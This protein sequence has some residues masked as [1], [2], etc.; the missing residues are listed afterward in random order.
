MAFDIS[1]AKPVGESGTPGARGFDLATAKPVEAPQSP[2]VMDRAS[3]ALTGINRGAFTRM[4]GLPVD[5]AAN[6]LDLLK[7]AGGTAYQA[8]TGKP[9]ESMQLTN[10]AD[11][12]G[13]GDWIEKQVRNMG[14]GS[15]IDPSG[16][17]DATSRALHAGGMGVGGAIAGGRMTSAPMTNAAMARNAAAGGLSGGAGAVAAENGASPE[18]Q[19]LAS[20]SPQA[21]SAATAGAAR[22]AVRGGEAGRR[23]MEQRI[24]DL[25]EAGIDSPSLGLASGNAFITGLENLSSKI[26]GSVGL[27]ADHRAKMIEGMMGK[28]AATRDL[29]SSQYGTDVAGRAIQSDLQSLLR[30]RITDGFERVNDQ[31]V[32]SMPP[33]QRFPIGNSLNALAGATAVN[34]LAPATTGSFVQPRIAAL[35]QNMLADS[36]ETQPGMYNNQQVNVGLPVSAIREVR[37]GIGKEAASRAIMGTPEQA[38]YKQVYGG[39]SKDIGGAAR[40]SD[41][42]A[43]P[44]PNN[45]GPAERAFNRGNKLYSAGMERI[46]QVQ[47]FANK[48]AP[49]QAY[50]ALMQSGKENVSTLRAVKKSVGEETRATVAAT[51]IDRMGRAKPGQQNDTGDAWSQET[52]LTNYNQLAPKARK[53]LFSGFKDAEQVFAQ[54]E[55][56]A[57]GS[58]MIRDSSKVW[59]NPS[60]TGGNTLAAGTIGGI[61]VNAF[62]NPLSSLAAIGGLGAARVGS[63]N[64]LLNPKANAAIASRSS[65]YNALADLY[66]ITIN[67]QEAGRER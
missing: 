42:S 66:P 49:E 12:V 6:V 26:P 45:M 21:L 28:A 51:A 37:T 39:L 55:A 48:D 46:A 18:L 11:V 8:V 15:L 19:I 30:P 25:K 40:M 34:P 41:I 7:A 53:E 62:I 63:Q 32:S 2:T 3:A 23:N 1:T 44:Q 67:A 35:R 50:N 64:L 27:Y 43:G 10:R 14:G 59:A 38:E 20:M 36:T 60:G 22:A 16:P 17:Q 47:P 31:M 29:A 13:S 58:S 5:T 61:A 57:K 24:H 4:A 52:F 65:P 33:N 9:A 56:L 54:V